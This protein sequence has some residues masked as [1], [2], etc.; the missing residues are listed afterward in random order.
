MTFRSTLKPTRE[1]QLASQR[2]PYA[3]KGL[4]RNL[5][6]LLLS[7]AFVLT[8]I[9][10]IMRVLPVEKFKV[11]KINPERTV[12]W[13]YDDLLGWK[14]LPGQE[15]RFITEDSN[16]LIKI[17]DEGFRDKS[18]TYQ[19]PPGGLRLLVL[20]DSIV[21]GWGVEQ[22]QIFTEIIEKNHPNLE[23][24][25]M[26][27]SGYSTDQ[28]YLLLKEVGLKYHP[29][30][31]LL[32]FFD[33]DIAGNIRSVNF[34]VYPKPKFAVVDGRLV[35]W[36]RPSAQVG[37]A[38]KVN[39]FLRTHSVLYNVSTRVFLYSPARPMEFLRSGVSRMTNWWAGSQN[40]DPFK[41]TSLI[42]I[43]MH[44][45][46][47]QH[48][49]EFVIVKVATQ[50]DGAMDKK[51]K[52]DPLGEFCRTRKI[53]YLD[54]AFPFHQYLQH[55]KHASLRFPH[56]RHWNAEAHKL[57]ASVIQSFLE[58]EGLVPTREMRL[59]NSKWGRSVAK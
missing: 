47:R 14:N 26:G 7:T 17:N 40:E 4:L 55:E 51:E 48:G 5:L 27:V 33:D 49:A 19:P 25:N 53:P 6:L 28:E 8:A 2:I 29:H 10:I 58:A 16:V 20:G 39:H 12:F 57:V 15:G 31:I 44:Q 24:I 1:S 30:L 13:H 22:K 36:Q 41:L 59:H 38:R 11:H 34:L 3:F 46:V 43:E 56:D 18:Y 45:L 37:I 32:M 23:V 54:L 42:L 21:W 52:D 50:G 9:E 35:L